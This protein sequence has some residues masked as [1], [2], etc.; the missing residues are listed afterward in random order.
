MKSSVFLQ[1]SLNH[2]WQ[3]KKKN[4][5]QCECDHLNNPWVNVVIEDTKSDVVKIKSRRF[6]QGQEE[7]GSEEQSK[8]E[9]RGMNL[10]ALMHTK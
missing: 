8:I 6:N 3:E 10:K 1:V 7:Q 4:K 9:K 5:M 2:L